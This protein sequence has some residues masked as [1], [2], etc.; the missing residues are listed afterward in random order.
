MKKSLLKLWINLG[1][2]YTA[3]VLLGCSSVSG[4]GQSADLKSNASLNQLVLDTIKAGKFDT[5]KMW[6]FDFPPKKFFKDEYNFDATDQWLDNVRMSALRF[7]TYCS[8]SFV[9]AD[10]LVMT[11]HH[12]AR[13]SVTDATRKGED[14]HTNGFYADSLSQ[15]R[16]IEGLFVDQ[17]VKIIDVTDEVQKALDNAKGET[18][19]KANKDKVVEKYKKETG[20]ECSI[21]SFYNGGKYSLYAY[22]RYKDVRLVFAPETQL[23]FYGGDPDNFTYPRYALDCSFFRVYDENGKPLKTDHFFKWSPEG[24][25]E[26]EPVFVVGNP[27][28]TKRLL[29]VAQLEYQRDITN[30]VT[31]DRLGDMIRI[32]SELIKEEPSREAKMQDKLFSFANSQKAYAGIEKGLLDPEL[33]QRKRAFEAKFKQG[34]QSNPKLNSVYGNLWSTIAD[35]RSEMRTIAIEQLMIAVDPRFSSKYL[36]MAS[37][38]I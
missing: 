25:S 29:T 6:T 27:G 33:L 7:A 34:V 14:L 23:G 26:G 2:L 9:S 1:I 28:T 24:P 11:N 38:L 10:G 18:E 35:A 13:E 12:C 17:L 31:L 15:E 16:K 36:N 20:L 22:K 5:G 4:V 32:Y 37:E 19:R 30:P 21:I 3:V 8:A